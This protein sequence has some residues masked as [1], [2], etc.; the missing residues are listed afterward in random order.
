M[1]YLSS[2]PENGTLL[3][4]YRRFPEAA[5]TQVLNSDLVMRGPS[6]LS[7]GER[8]LIAAYVSSLNACRYCFGGHAKVAEAFGLDISVLRHLQD[9]LDSA[10]VDEKLKPIL[11]YV[12]KLTETPSRMT[13]ADAQAVYHAG[14]SEAAFFNAVQVCCVFNYMNRLVDGLG[15]AASDEQAQI[16]GRMLYDK[17]YAAILNMLGISGDQ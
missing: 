1:T 9:D 10:P 16:T 5:R 8:E 6:P 4:L 17:G 15:L 2:L 14:W 3:D 13:E 11:R 7:P 12:K